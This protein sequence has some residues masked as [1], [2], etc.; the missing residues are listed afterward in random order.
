MLTPRDHFYRDFE[1]FVGEVA[2]KPLVVDLGTYHGFRKE[3]ADQR[4]RF[5]GKYFTMD[6]SC[7]F[8]DEQHQRPNVLG[9]LH[10]LPFRSSSVSGIIC[11]E[12][13]EHVESPALA[14]QEMHRTL[15]PGGVLFCSIPFLHP[16]HGG[17]SLADY[18]RF[19]HE[20]TLQLFREFS[21]V[22]VR[23]T[24][25]LAF[26]ARAFSPRIVRRLFFSPVL[27]PVVNWLDSFT[28]R[29]GATNLF[30]VLARK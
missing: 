21:Q 2:Q 24:G 7:S 1:A 8:D 11:K 3:L 30:L 25:G 13:L 6:L 15:V 10:R 29:F 5:T 19:T 16:Y 26:V 9:D 22:D 23:R 20:G 12:V 17:P 28:L 4:T 18:W 14:V 27:M